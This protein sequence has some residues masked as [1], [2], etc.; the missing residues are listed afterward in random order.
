VVC[1]NPR[2]YLSNIP[3]TFA[4]VRLEL[5]TPPRQ[6]LRQSTRIL[7]VEPTAA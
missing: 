6:G 1:T 2:A 5:G 7:G 3:D 4:E